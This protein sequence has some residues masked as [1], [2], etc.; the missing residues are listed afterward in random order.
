MKRRL[1]RLIAHLQ[2][3]KA[4]P[5]SCGSGTV[6]NL[7]GNSHDVIVGGHNPLSTPLLQIRLAAPEPEKT[8]IK[9]HHHA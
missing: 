1:K 9:H 6:S 2:G 7:N 4:A 3:I 8:E 5:I